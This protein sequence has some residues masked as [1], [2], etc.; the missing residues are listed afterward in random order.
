MI[1]STPS[2]RDENG[3]NKEKYLSQ[4]YRIGMNA[5]SYERYIYQKGITN[6]LQNSITNTAFLTKNEKNDLIKFRHHKR[7]ISYIIFDYNDIKEDIELKEQELKEEYENNLEVYRS[8]AYAKYLYLDID[9]NDLVKN[10]KITDEQARKIYNLNL[11][12]GVM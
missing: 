2:F 4:L 7:D 9:K 3:F 12:E 10:I 6:Q 8:P 1:N 5:N 11:E